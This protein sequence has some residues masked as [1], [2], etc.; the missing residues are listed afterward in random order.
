MTNRGDSLAVLARGL[1]QAER[2]LGCVREDHLRRPTPCEEWD[3]ADLADHM[4][5]GI[6]NFERVVRGQDVDWTAPTPH[7]EG[8]HAAAFRVHADGLI[9]AWRA[10]PDEAALPGPDWQT[11]EVAVHS[12]DLATA[13]GQRTGELDAAVAERGLAFMRANLKPE[14]R[15]TAFGPEQPAPEGADPYRRIAAFAGRTG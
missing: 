3:V 11:A 8:D 2:L 10:A 6:A 4:V 13:L 12:Y 5:A 1:D 9:A 14:M 7:V 15:S